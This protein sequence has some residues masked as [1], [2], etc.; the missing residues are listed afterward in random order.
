MEHSESAVQQQEKVIFCTYCV[1]TS[2]PASKTCLHCEAS[3]CDKHINIHS[4]SVEHVLTDPSI[5]LENKKCSIHKKLLEFYCT[6]DGACICASC[7]IIGE[8][9]GHKM[10]SLN[11]AFE[12]KV[13]DLRANLEKLSLVRKNTEDQVQHLQQQGQ[14]VKEKLS[15]VAG[16][17]N[18]LLSDIKVQ[19]DILEKQVHS[20]ITRQ[21][22]LALL[23]VSDLTRQLEIKKEELSKK[24]LHMEELSKMTD[25][26]TVLS[27]KEEEKSNSQTNS[28]INI[29]SSV[30]EI[31]IS[32]VL[33]SGLLSLVDLLLELKA[34]K[35]FN[36]LK[37]SD[38]LL[39]VNTAHNKIVVSKD[40]KSASYS[41]T[42]QKY[43]DGPERFKSCQVLS[44]G[45][46]SSGRHY[47]EVDLK[48]ASRW[49]V[50]VACSSIERKVA[51]NESFIGYNNK[52]WS[53]FFQKYLGVSHNNIQKNIASD[54]PVQSIGI[55]LDYEA[56]RLSF[57]QLSYPMRH[58]HTFTVT[59]TEPLHAAFYIFENTAIRIKS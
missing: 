5:S 42:S 49:I 40:L 45:A 38:V 7:C 25:P 35:Q 32:L 53:L 31:P 4:K 54:S 34:K 3:L 55:Y 14:I 24:I 52:S 33:H 58:L 30:D 11:E 12:K 10:E 48:E 20:E 57:Y 6:K 43:P 13:A 16:T 41:V 23:Q 19:V 44:I 46:F 26:L 9:R 18:T 28:D 8:H 51:G 17:Y 27:Y 15:G 22:D 36:V 2:V 59:F 37:P 1:H 47:W 56:G 29:N 21:E 50:G 39:D